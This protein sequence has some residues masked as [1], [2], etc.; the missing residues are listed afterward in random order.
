MSSFI[1]DV[2][3]TLEEAKIWLRKK[4]F[5]GGASCPCC[6]QFAKVYERRL[7]SAMAYALVVFSRNLKVNEWVSVPE[8]L[9]QGKHT[10]IVRSRE[11]SRLR[12]WG[13]IEQKLDIRDDGSRETGVYRLTQA[14]HDFAHGKSEAPAFVVMYDERVLKK[15]Q[16]V[17]SIREALGSK[18]DYEVLMRPTSDHMVATKE[19]E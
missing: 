13:F 1:A 10:S 7:N 19:N 15:S 8:F 6:N 11:W 14:G 5:E 16:E 18:F 12:F 2:G 3:T 4:V 9:E 17:V